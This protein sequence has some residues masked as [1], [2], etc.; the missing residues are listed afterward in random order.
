MF[1]S[2]K[3]VLLALVAFSVHI[4]V[5]GGLK[6]VRVI[7]PGGVP[8]GESIKLECHFDTEGDKLYAVKWYKGKKEFYRYLPKDNPPGKV[9]PSSGVNVNLTMSGLNRVVIMDA[10][11]GLSDKY[12]CEVSVEAPS[13]DTALVM[14]PVY[15]VDFP[16][17]DPVIS[18]E[19]QTYPVGEILKANCTSYRNHPSVNITWAING[20]PVKGKYVKTLPRVLEDG[21][22]TTTTETLKAAVLPESFRNGKMKLECT[23]TM[24]NVYNRTTK[25]IIEEENPRA[26]LVLSTTH[27]SASSTGLKGSCGAL[28]VVVLVAQLLL[29]LSR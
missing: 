16:D 4:F 26:A 5:V 12:R 13:F 9:F 7:S 6:D 10:H 22:L 18:L 1:A 14:A 28:V 8:V 24:Y 20:L 2:T 17:G 15:V 11:F 25:A 19:R 27:D 29:A 23:A 21:N 3:H